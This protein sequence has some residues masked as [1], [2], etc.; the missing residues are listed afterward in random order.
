[1]A[2]ALGGGLWLAVALARRHLAAAAGTEGSYVA[3]HAGLVWGVGVWSAW[4]AMM[5]RRDEPPPGAA[6][7]EFYVWSFLLLG[8]ATLPLWLFAGA[9]WRRLVRRGLGEPG[10]SDR[11]GAV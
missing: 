2:A 1:M 9:G 4:T 10:G 11:D 3:R 6:P 5:V 7:A 8:A